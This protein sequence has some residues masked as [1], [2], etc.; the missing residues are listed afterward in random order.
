MKV[1]DPLR[2]KEVE[3]TPEENVRQSVIVWL[4]D[5]CGIPEVRMKSEVPFQYNGL[6]YRADI[7]VYER[8]LDPEILIECKAPSVKIDRT[9]IEQVIRYTRVLK[10]KKIVV[11]NG[12][13]TFF[14]RWNGSEYVPS[15]VL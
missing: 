2:K 4:R 13:T 14:F 12:T 1:F 5:K 3:L 10:V 7:L 6:Q 11:T 8:N 15:P 9:V